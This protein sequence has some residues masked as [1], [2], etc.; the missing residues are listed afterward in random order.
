MAKLQRA[1]GAA[2]ATLW[3]GRPRPSLTASRSGRRIWSMSL[4]EQALVTNFA[5][6]LAYEFQKIL[7]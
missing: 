6:R 4:S 1:G 7:L 2:C 3:D 5:T